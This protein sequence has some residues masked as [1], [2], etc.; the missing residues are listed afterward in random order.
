M[1]NQIYFLKT[2]LPIASCLSLYLCLALSDLLPVIFN[3]YSLYCVCRDLTL[4]QRQKKS[5]SP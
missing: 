4:F 1:F 3:R 2:Y 5:T